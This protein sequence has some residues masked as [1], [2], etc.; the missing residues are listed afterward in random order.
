MG[1]D[2]EDD[3]FF[4]NKIKKTNKGYLVNIVEYLVDYS[5]ENYNKETKD[6]SNLYIK[7]LNEDIIATINDGEDI[8]IVE[9]VKNNID[10]FSSKII[11]IIKEKD[12]KLHIKSVK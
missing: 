12:G 3:S 9:S 6:T 4:I 8:G 11:T 2:S 5:E 7:N 10:K 1:L